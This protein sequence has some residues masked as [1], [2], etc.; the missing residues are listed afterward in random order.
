MSYLGRITYTL[1]GRYNVIATG[2]V[3]GSS[4]YPKNNRYG[5]FPSLGL[6]WTMSEE[7]FLKG[8][9]WMDKLKLRASYGVVGND[10]GVSNA[11]TLYANSVNIVTGPNNDIYST[12]ALEINVRH[13]PVLGRDEIFQSRC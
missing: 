1:K 6:G 4:S 11:Q 5:F 8:A 13:H 3:D 10:K 7:N 9:R 12:D 2:R